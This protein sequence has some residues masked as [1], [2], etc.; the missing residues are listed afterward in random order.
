MSPERPIISAF[1]AIA[2]S[3]IRSAGTIT[4]SL[5]EMVHVAKEMTRRGIRM[6]LLIGGAT[7]SRQHTA[8][9]IAPAYEG[10]T[11]HVL[12]ASRAV[13]VVSDLLGESTREAFDEKNRAEQD[14][15]RALHEGK[16]EKPLLS[17]EAARE[18]RVPIE[19]RAD[20]LPTPDFVG[21]RVL[22]DV[23]VAELRPF[24]DW[25]FFFTAW[26]LKGRFPKILDH[27][28]YGAEA[29]ELYENA[30]KLLDRIEEDASIRAH[31]VYGFWPAASDGD[32][33]VVYDPE[34]PTEE[35]QRFPMLRQQRPNEDRPL[36]CLADFVAPQ[37]SGLRDHI[38][39]FAVTGGVGA[40]AHDHL[41]ED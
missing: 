1:S 11:V 24:I 6:P 10:P 9:K 22:R 17:I 2:V 29:R 19:W 30:N 41:N 35:L 38:G 26:E 8:V 37:D 33:I 21:R 20:D 16:Q 32:D 4:P 23:P 40:E 3:R 5:D 18:R 28:E 36:H 25:T 34:A 27:P 39:A 15:L 14:R 7:T 31:G 13:T 12:D